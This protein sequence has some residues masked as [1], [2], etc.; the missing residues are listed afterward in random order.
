[1]T[2][3]RR[4][5]FASIPLFATILASTTPAAAD[6]P[7]RVGDEAPGARSVS[8]TTNP[9]SA[10]FGIGL[11]SGEVALPRRSLL[12]GHRSIDIGVGGWIGLGRTRSADLTGLVPVWSSCDGLFSCDRTTVF[13]VGGQV[14]AYPLGTFEHGLQLGV[15]AGFV[16]VQGTRHFN[17][18]YG[19]L[20]SSIAHVR[21]LPDVGTSDVPLSGNAFVPGLVVGYKLITRPGLTFN[22]QVAG[23]VVLSDAPTR[24]V[25]R[26]ALNA[27]WSF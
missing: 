17:A 24:L 15:E 6:E 27:G 21:G 12:P 13:S 19:R 20:A 26:L 11:V 25:P 16:H 2:S 9:I 3:L 18:A 14:F 1:M 10:L 5:L 8:L 22:P 7:D 23:D 4:S